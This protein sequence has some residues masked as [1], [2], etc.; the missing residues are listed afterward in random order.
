[1]FCLGKV[2]WALQQGDKKAA[3]SLG[4]STEKGALLLD[5]VLFSWKQ[6]GPPTKILEVY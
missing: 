6:N 1:M 5:G 2:S 3:Q 4:M